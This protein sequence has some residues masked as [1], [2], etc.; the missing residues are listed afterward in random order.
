MSDLIRFGV[1]ID[2]DL[3]TK[4][5]EQITRKG[6]TNRSE[7]LRDLIR[8]NLVAEEWV[9]GD[10]NVGTITLVYDHHTPDLSQAMTHLQHSFLGEIKSVLHIHMDHNNCLEVLIV[11]GEGAFI[12]GLADQLISLRG[13]KHGKLTMTTS[14]KALPSVGGHHARGHEHEVEHQHNRPMRS[15]SARR[16]S[17][18]RRAAH[19]SKTIRHAAPMAGRKK[20]L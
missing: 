6:Y 19:P 3:L 4:F 16:K 1:S 5:D 11:Q 7:A 2:G 13:I 10:Q 20:R 12:K 14:G 8:D 15:H 9:L 17:K 18:V